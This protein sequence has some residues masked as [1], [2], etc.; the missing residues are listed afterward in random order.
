[1]LIVK[2]CLEFTEYSKNI[3]MHF[4]FLAT[5]FTFTFCLSSQVES[6]IGVTIV[7]SPINEC[8]DKQCW[9]SG[10]NSVLKTDDE[11]LVVNTATMTLVG[12]KASYVATC[13]CGATTF[14]DEPLSCGTNACFNG[15][16]CIASWSGYR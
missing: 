11:P 14:P 2:L 16:V 6:A 7:S 12:M 8:L 3:S 1:M 4:I 13:E 5:V 9:D 15:G 10:C